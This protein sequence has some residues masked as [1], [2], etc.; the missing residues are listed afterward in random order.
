MIQLEPQDEPRT[1][2]TIRQ[3]RLPEDLRD[4]HRAG[5]DG[6]ATQP[7]QLASL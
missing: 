4:D 1:L 7:D 3:G 6:V 5:W 2:M